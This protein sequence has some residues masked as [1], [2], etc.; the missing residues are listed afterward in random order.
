LRSGNVV[1]SGAGGTLALGGMTDVASFDLSTIGAIGRGVLFQGFTYCDKWRTSTWTATGVANGI[2]AY[3]LLQ[4]TLKLVGSGDLSRAKSVTVG[5]KPDI[6]CVLD[7]SGTIGT[8]KTLQQLTIIQNSQVLVGDKTLVLSG[9]SGSLQGAISGTGSV[10]I[11]GSYTLSSTG[12]IS[13]GTTV[14]P[15]GTLSVDGGSIGGDVTIA[16]GLVVYDDNE[17]AFGGNVTISA[18]GVV[19]VSVYTSKETVVTIKGNL[20]FQDSSCHLTNNT[21]SGKV[22]TIEVA[23]EVNLNGVT[24][25]ISNTEGNFGT[26]ILLRASGGIKGT[27]TR[28]QIDVGSVRVEGN[29]LILIVSEINQT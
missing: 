18:N 9:G 29:A 5:Y 16:G 26:Y 22:G 27:P 25:D 12:N 21:E 20:N 13:A 10:T 11:A 7:M 2:E 28:G 15:P 14:S 8:T 19:A 17:T 6:S 23:G 24:V 4:G 3:R 1:C